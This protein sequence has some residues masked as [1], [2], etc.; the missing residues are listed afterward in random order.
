MGHSCLPTSVR[1]RVRVRVRVSS[2]GPTQG[3]QIRIARGRGRIADR[4]HL[5][6][7]SGSVAK[8][9]VKVRG[10]GVTM[11]VRAKLPPLPVIE[12]YLSPH[13]PTPGTHKIQRSSYKVPHQVL[14]G[15]N[16]FIEV[17]VH[18]P[19]IR[20]CSDSLKPCHHCRIYLPKVTN[21]QE[22]DCVP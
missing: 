8:L 6:R 5:P 1:L 13:E 3:S 10:S 22:A 2:P 4:H 11:M 18:V 14:G 9:R 21:V 12:S 15:G 16:T 19:P 20:C 17:R 7:I